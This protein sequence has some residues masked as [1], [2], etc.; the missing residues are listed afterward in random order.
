MNAQKT[1]RPAAGAATGAR[2][3]S[4]VSPEFSTF[5]GGARVRNAGGR[6]CGRISAGVLSKRARPEHMLRRPPAWAWDADILAQA[7]AAGCRWTEVCDVEGG[8]IYRASLADFRQHGVPVNRGFGRQ[9]ALPLAWWRVHR[10]GE[11]AAV[12][13]ELFGGQP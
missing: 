12:Q 8:R 9:I 5:R 10:P 4:Y 7:E 2:A 3:A 11:P 13:L 6:V 1:P